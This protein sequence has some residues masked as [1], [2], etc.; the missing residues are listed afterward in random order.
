MGKEVF[1]LLVHIWTIRIEDRGRPEG[2]R[3]ATARQTIGLLGAKRGG[4]VA[5]RG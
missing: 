5:I 2:G 4:S 3:I 1:D